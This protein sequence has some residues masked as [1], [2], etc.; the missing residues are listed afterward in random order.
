MI[1]QQ[2]LDLYKQAKG[3][4]F[5]TMPSKINQVDISKDEWTLIETLLTFVRLINKRLNQ[6]VFILTLNTKLAPV[7]AHFRMRVFKTLVQQGVKKCQRFGMLAL[8]MFV[9]QASP[10]TTK[11]I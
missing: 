3:I 7:H 1:T 10:M 6:E 11:S 8:S 4:F 9:G 5:Y 2:K